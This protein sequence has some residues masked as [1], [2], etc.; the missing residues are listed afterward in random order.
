MA[1]Q[2]TDVTNTGLGSIVQYWHNETLTRGINTTYTNSTGRPILVSIILTST[3]G[4]QNATLYVNSI[5]V[6]YITI[7]VQSLS[8]G[9]GTFIVNNGS[10]YK[11]AGT[12]LG[13]VSWLEFA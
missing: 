12:S 5:N 6:G 4:Q 3:S 10:T 11:I 13:V 2:L 1:I 7:A 9:T 8:N